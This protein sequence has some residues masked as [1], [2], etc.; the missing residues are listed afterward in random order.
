MTDL[1]KIS[2]LITPIAQKYGAD[3]VALFGSRA[4]NTAIETSDYDFVISRGKIQSLF[5]LASFIDELE[6]AFGKNVDVITDT[7]NDTAFL[8]EIK[9][10]EVVVYEAKR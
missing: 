4:K 6:M 9:K 8:E 7:S 10:D 2:K 5:Q 1:K 3:R